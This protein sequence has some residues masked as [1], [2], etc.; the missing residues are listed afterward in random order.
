MPQSITKSENNQSSIIKTATFHKFRL[1]SLASVC[2]GL[3]PKDPHRGSAP[4]SWNSVP[5]FL[6]YSPWQNPTKL[7]IIIITYRCVTVIWFFCLQV[8]I[9]AALCNR[10]GHYIFVL[11][12]L[13]FFL[14]MAALC[15]RC[16]HYV[17]ALPVVSIFLLF[18][19]LISTVGDWMS[20]ILPHIVWT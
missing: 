20:T 15:G 19:R 12:F 14:L 7:L 3:S 17:F 9:M 1:S 4:N 10:A 2:M 5:I 6:F 11:W 16:G 18:P 8:L 13:Y